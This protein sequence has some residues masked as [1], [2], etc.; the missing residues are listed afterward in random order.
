MGSRVLRPVPSSTGVSHVTTAFA[1][2]SGGAGATE[3]AAYELFRPPACTTSGHVAWR[4]SSTVLHARP[5]RL[6]MR[7]MPAVG[8][9]DR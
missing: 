7:K 5:G 1:T 9:N 3:A 2:K 8:N 4:S 6:V